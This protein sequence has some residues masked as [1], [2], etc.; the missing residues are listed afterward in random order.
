MDK[1]EAKMKVSLIAHH[2]ACSLHLCASS[3][4]CLLYLSTYL[5]II[6]IIIIITTE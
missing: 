6:L 2:E 1:D 4:F 3:N 5:C